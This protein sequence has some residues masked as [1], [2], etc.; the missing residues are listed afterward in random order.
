[1]LAIAFAQLWPSRRLGAA[2]AAAAVAT[3][4]TAA[5]G[6]AAAAAHCPAAA[7]PPPPL[8]NHPPN[9]PAEAYTGEYGSMAEEVYTQRISMAQGR[10]RCQ[11]FLGAEMVSLGAYDTSAAAALLTHP[12][13]VADCGATTSAYLLVC[14][15]RTAKRTSA[16]EWSNWV[17]SDPAAQAT[18]PAF[19]DES[20]FICVRMTVVATAVAEVGST[21]QS[22]HPPPT[23]PA[24]PGSRAGPTAAAAAAVATAVAAKPTA[25]AQAAAPAEPAA[26]SKTAAAAAAGRA[27]RRRVF[28]FAQPVPSHLRRVRPR[29]AAPDADRHGVIVRGLLCAGLSQFRCAL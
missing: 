2:V 26:V 16:I 29:R 5:A 8:P 24:P 28:G 1:M 19:A 22:P 14:E 27:V 10:A 6:A 3:A 25:A 17:G 21:Q 15:K 18:A 20:P 23:P 4:T 12:S 13:V 11:M 7:A 9:A